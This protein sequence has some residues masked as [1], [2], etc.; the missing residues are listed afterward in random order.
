MAYETGTATSPSDLLE[1][2]KVF[3]AA[4]EWT[5]NLWDNDNSTNN[6]LLS[7]DTTGKRLHIQKTAADGTVMYFNFRS[8]VRMFLFS[9]LSTSMYSTWYDS[10]ITGIAMNGSTGFE[11]T[12]EIAITS[13]SNKTGGQVEIT[14]NGSH[15]FKQGDT[16]TISGTTDY[17]GSFL[18]AAYAPTATTFRIVHAYTSSQTG[19]VS[20]PTSWAKQP[21]YQHK[22]DNIHSRGCCINALQTGAVPNYYIFSTAN[23]DSIVVVVEYE[24]GK[25]QFMCFGLL[26]KAGAYTGGQFCAASCSSYLPV[27]ARYTTNSLRKMAFLGPDDTSSTCWSQAAVYANFDGLADWRQHDYDTETTARFNGL[28]P[29]Q[30][31]DTTN[32]HLSLAEG[33]IKRTPNSFSA[34]APMLPFYVMVKRTGTNLWSLAGWIEEFRQLRIDNFANAEEVSFGADTWKVFSAHNRSVDTLSGYGYAVKKVV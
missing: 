26:H 28:L 10:E 18:I 27:Y 2:I 21:G 31:I 6:L 32:T 29:N 5:I 8:A 4:N 23:N 14:T 22:P 16:V 15:Q 7:A 11:A 25:F 30:L 20:G 17:N 9:E 13:I 19:L 24:N 33:F 34:L 3:L 1:K 12:H